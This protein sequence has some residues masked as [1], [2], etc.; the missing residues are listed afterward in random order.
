MTESTTEIND[1][2]SDNLMLILMIIF[3]VI[4]QLNFAKEAIEALPSYIAQQDL[5]IKDRWEAQAKFSLN[6]VYYGILS[7]IGMIVWRV[8]H[9][10][11][12][13]F[14]F[15]ILLLNITGIILAIFVLIK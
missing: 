12:I 14:I 10:E 6:S 13:K 5:E 4:A 7:I 9:K 11:K 1:N 15:P 2:S 8:A 3:I